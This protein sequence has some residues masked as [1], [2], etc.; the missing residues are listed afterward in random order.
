MKYFDAH[1]HI[2]F[3]QYAEDRE[4]V[5]A[6]MAEK[7]IG[8][9]VVG[10]DAASSRAAAEFVQG[11]EG[12]YASVGQHPNDN[13]AEVY[14]EHLYRNLLMYPNVVAI[15]ECGLDYFRPTDVTDEVKAKQ[16]E[17]F[18]RQVRLAGETKRPLIVHARPS[19]GTMDAYN[20]A[21]AIV[22]D[23]KKEYSDAL[24]G[25]FHFF[26]GDVDVAKKIFELDFTVSYTAVITFARNYDEVIRYAP[27]DRILAE[28]DSPYV[29]PVSRR[30][31][32]N[33]P[34]SIPEIVAKLAQIRREDEETVRAAVLANAEKLFKLG[35]S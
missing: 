34:L 1:C 35:D 4:A 27:L 13:H 22:A 3:D 30:G 26:V 12:F 25:D 20:D 32:R 18:L 15:G 21:L 28:T 23:A 8:G 31:Q 11:K 33:D 29:A 17:L 24:T 16:K 5:T 2:Q 19:K 9:L 7:E 6:A 10:C 14:D